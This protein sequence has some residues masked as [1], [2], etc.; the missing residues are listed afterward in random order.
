MSHGGA[1]YADGFGERAAP[2]VAE[3]SLGQTDHGFSIHGYIVARYPVVYK[4]RAMTHNDGLSF[5]GVT[6]MDL[7]TLITNYLSGLSVH[8]LWIILAAFMA[9]STADEYVSPSQPTWPKWAIA[10]RALL[11][12]LDNVLTPFVGI[13][14]LLLRIPVAS[15]PPAPKAPQ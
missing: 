13:V 3:F 4:R 8:D 10:A 1:G 7:T 6:T 12:T 14:R 9:I 2:F 11:H 5:V 15:P